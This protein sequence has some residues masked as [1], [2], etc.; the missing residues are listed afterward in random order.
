MDGDDVDAAVR[1][2]PPRTCY[3]GCSIGSD[4]LVATTTLDQLLHPGI[5]HRDRRCSIV[6]LVL[7][8]RWRCTVLLPVADGGDTSFGPCSNCD[9]SRRS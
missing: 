6:Q 3:M 2:L 1:S 5:D 8:D 9:L 7:Q 4:E